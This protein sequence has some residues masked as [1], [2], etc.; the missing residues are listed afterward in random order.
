MLAGLLVCVLLPLLTA[1]RTWY[2]H[3]EATPA[4]IESDYWDTVQGHNRV[5]VSL[6]ASNPALESTIAC[7]H[8]SLVQ[9]RSRAADSRDAQ[10]L[11][12]SDI[13]S[14]VYG[15]GFATSLDDPYSKFGWN[16]N[17]LPGLPE[18]VLKHAS[19]ISGE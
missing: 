12:G 9:W 11:Y 7:L 18:S 5:S 2:P 4:D 19:G 10:V 1:A 6:L 3:Q 8:P 16:L 15:S 13:D 14:T 17:V